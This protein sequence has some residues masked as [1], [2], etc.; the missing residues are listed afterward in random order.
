MTAREQ[1]ELTQQIV[2][3]TTGVSIEEMRGRRN[4]LEIS[5]T[6]QVAMWICAQI[7]E[8]SVI[9][10]RFR[11]LPKHVISRLF[12]REQH[13]VVSHAVRAVNN[14]ID[15]E[16]SVGPEVYRLRDRVMAEIKKRSEVAN[17]IEFPESHAACAVKESGAWSNQP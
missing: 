5:W 1:I 14:A 17:V 8:Y 15:V 10:R 13:S 4:I 6:R 12:H 3:E 7:G 11:T 16:P 2:A 9:G